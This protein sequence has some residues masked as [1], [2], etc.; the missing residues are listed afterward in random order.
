[1]IFGK[2][3]L[4]HICQ[5]YPFCPRHILLTLQVF[6]MPVAG[7]DNLPVCIFKA[8]TTGYPLLLRI[9]S[10]YL[11]SSHP[12]IKCGVTVLQLGCHGALKV[13]R[14]L[15]A[16]HIKHIRWA[17]R[18]PFLSHLLMCQTRTAI[19]CPDVDSH[20]SG[21]TMLQKSGSYKGQKGS[22]WIKNNVNVSQLKLL[23]ELVGFTVPLCL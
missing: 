21:S 17:P 5:K 13:H 16:V 6:C 3:Y 20:L 2:D 4:T 8:V 1:M 19:A 7:C 18:S 22:S 14:F 15:P 9:S 11:T 12:G 10:Q 23:L